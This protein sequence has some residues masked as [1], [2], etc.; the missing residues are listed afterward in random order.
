LNQATPKGYNITVIS[1]PDEHIAELKAR[2]DKTI[3]VF[4]HELVKLRTGRANPAM[5]EDVKVDYYGTH[6]PLKHLARM[7]APEPDMIVI[8]PFDKTQVHAIEKAIQ[9]ANLGFNPTVDGELLRIKVPRLTEE[10]RKELSKVI[11]DKAEESKV[12]LRNIRREIKEHLDKEQKAGK[13]SEDDHDRVMKEIEKVTH[14]YT[15]KIDQT[16]QTKE[17]QLLSV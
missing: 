16:A 5:V 4:E 12:A 6:T 7:T 17:K 10:R 13:I 14:E 8:Y 1:M 9:A 11:H 15:A 3:Q 2:M